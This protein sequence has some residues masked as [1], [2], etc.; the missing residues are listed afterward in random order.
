MSSQVEYSSLGPLAQATGS[1]PS[2]AGDAG[3]AEVIRTDE[4]RTVVGATGSLAG[5]GA[6]ANSDRAQ[7]RARALAQR[8][9]DDIVKP[10][11]RLEVSRDEDSGRF[12]YKTID[13]RTGEVIRTWPA[14][15]VVH[16]L[17]AAEAIEA[18]GVVRCV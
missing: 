5:E 6:E 16:L 14:E 7:E 18:L 15:P 11:A 9:V 13:E 2:S 8:L 3:R 17:G 12:V 4:A 10:F 1:A